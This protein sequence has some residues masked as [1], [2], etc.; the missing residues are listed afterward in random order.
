M[1]AKNNGSDSESEELL[2]VGSESRED[3][4]G[5]ESCCSG[6]GDK[7]NNEHEN[8]NEGN[9]IDDGTRNHITEQT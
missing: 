3:E 5:D 8:E 2:D 4:T 9:D 7:D 6:Y 1:L